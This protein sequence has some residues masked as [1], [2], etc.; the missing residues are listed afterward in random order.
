MLLRAFAFHSMARANLNKSVWL[1][2]NTIAATKKGPSIE[3]PPFRPHF[4]KF[5]KTVSYEVN[6]TSQYSLLQVLLLSKFESE[7]Q[8]LDI[9]Q[10]VCNYHFIFAILQKYLKSKEYRNSNA[11]SKTLGLQYVHMY[12]A[13]TEFNK[14]AI[15]AI[16]VNFNY[17]TVQLHPNVYYFFLILFF[18][19][20]FADESHN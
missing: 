5:S 8:I 2:T 9:L 3:I 18:S 11:I 17:V 20:F 6:L 12:F 19:C 1:V 10:P 13:A 14:L 4:L 7:R 16:R 15:M